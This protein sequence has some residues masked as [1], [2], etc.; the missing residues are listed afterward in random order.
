V[1]A[2]GPGAYDAKW[3]LTDAN[4]DTRTVLTHFVEAG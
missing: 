1:Q 3:V 4:G 2:L